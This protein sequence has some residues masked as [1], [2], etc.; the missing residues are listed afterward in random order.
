MS[1][2]P[3]TSHVYGRLKHWKGSDRAKRFLLL[4]TYLVSTG[5]G[6][7]GAGER[8]VSRYWEGRKGHGRA[9]RVRAGRQNRR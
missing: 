2:P 3:Q 7:T 9:G 5:R 4:W 6:G 1:C 8:G